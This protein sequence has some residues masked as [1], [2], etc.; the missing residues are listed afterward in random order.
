MKSLKAQQSSLSDA[1]HQLSIIAHGETGDFSL[2]PFQQKLGQS[3]LYPLR[4]AA[5][6]IFQVNIVQ[7]LQRFDAVF[8]NAV[9]TL[10]VGSVLRIKRQGRNHLNMVRFIKPGQVVIF[11]ISQNDSQVAA[12]NDMF[13]EL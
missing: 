11:F 6:E 4:P 1:G 12:D 9:A 2:V 10:P 5:I 8:K 3:G 13:S 7:H